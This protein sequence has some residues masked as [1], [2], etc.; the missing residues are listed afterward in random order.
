MKDNAKKS[1]MDKKE[2]TALKR[3]V[4][5]WVNGLRKG[6]Y[7]KPLTKLPTG[8][9]QD[10]FSCVIHNCFS[11][12]GR[13]NVQCTTDYLTYRKGKEETELM[14]PV[15]AKSFVRLFDRGEF[16]ELVRS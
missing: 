9:Q 1:K 8:Y 16:P 14:L 10:I 6:I 3:E 7:R 5:K 2:K 4:L 15:F 12:A 13:K 11:P